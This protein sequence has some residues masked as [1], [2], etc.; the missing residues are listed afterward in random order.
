ML[1][2]QLLLL[3]LLM[4]LLLLTS[5]NRVDD[6]TWDIV[7]IVHNVVVVVY[8]RNPHLKFGP[9]WAINSWDIADIEFVV[10]GGR[11]WEVG[12]YAKLFSC[13]SQFLLF[14]VRLSCGW[15]GVVTFASSVI[16]SL[17]LWHGHNFNILWIKVLVDNWNNS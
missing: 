7:V 10:G 6:S 14:Y 16:L 15:V 5:K 2:L 9:N 8:P 12:W 1:L 13:Q 4:M 11:R 3:M 17:K